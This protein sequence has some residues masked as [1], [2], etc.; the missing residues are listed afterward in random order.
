MTFLNPP[1]FST[2]GVLSASKVNHM[3]TDIDTLYGWHYGP[4]YGCD[5]SSGWSA[6]GS[7]GWG[8]WVILAG[9][10][11]LT[12]TLADFYGGAIAK[13]YFNDV[14]VGQ[15]AGY[16]SAGT[17]TITLPIGSNGWDNW[18]PYRIKITNTQPSGS[19]EFQITNVY[20]KRATV[21]TPGTMPDFHDEDTSSAAD[22]NAIGDGIRLLEPAMVQP[23]AGVRGGEQYIV[24]GTNTGWTTVQLWKIQ[25]RLNGIR[26]S[27]FLQGPWQTGTISA[28]ILFNST[29]V[30]GAEWSVNAMQSRRITDQA[31]S[32]PGT[33]TV[34]N[35]YDMALQIKQSTS[36]LSGWFV[37]I[38][39]VYQDQI[40]LPAGYVQTLR[41][42]H[43]DY[44]IGDNGGGPTLFDMSK[45]IGYMDNDITST[46]IVNI[47]QRE[48][49]FTEAPHYPPEDRRFYHTRRWRWLAYKKQDWNADG[50]EATVNWTYDGKTWDSYQ[51]PDLDGEGGF[52]DLDSSPIVPGMLFYAAGCTYAIQSPYPGY[53][54]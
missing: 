29:A 25:H 53:A 8:G 3:L 13:V 40:S 35:F 33:P 41:W 43:G 37:R 12:V 51:L 17:K 2:G 16:T 46:G 28:R 39:Y 36:W 1:T 38:Y 26:C 52:Y 19:G 50:P 18:T 27:L 23:V 21:P 4:W 11:T 48:P 15:P 24:Q 49:I 9:N 45:N 22:F 10:D 30:N 6:T 5:Q 54:P 14:Q 47:A 42:Q 32:V 44:A 20:L 7:N 34:G 31:F